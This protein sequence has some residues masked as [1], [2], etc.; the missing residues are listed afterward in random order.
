[1][2]LWEMHVAAY[3]HHHH[4]AAPPASP[5]YTPLTDSVKLPAVPSIAGEDTFRLFTKSMTEGIR[6]K[7]SAEA[8]IKP[9]TRDSSAKHAAGHVIPAQ[10]ELPKSATRRTS[11]SQV[12]WPGVPTRLPRKLGRGPPST[13]PRS[14][15]LPRP[16]QRSRSPSRRTPQ[17]AYSCSPS[18][19]KMGP[20]SRLPHQRQLHSPP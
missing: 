7:S 11:P 9:E 3:H 1:M 20:R 2:R 10:Y 13:G 19:R 18:L 12:K 4:P 16:H 15:S 6:I 17:T 5:S 8:A 14:Y